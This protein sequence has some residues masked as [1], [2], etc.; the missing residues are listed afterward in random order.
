LKNRPGILYITNIKEATDILK[1]KDNISQKLKL[2]YDKENEIII[3]SKYYLSFNSDYTEIYL[4]KYNRELVNTYKNIDDLDVEVTKHD[5]KYD[6][7]PP[8]LFGEKSSS[9]YMFYS[10]IFD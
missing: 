3:S 7:P 9:H 2:G 4:K 6:E 1:R 8:P 5:N 10:G